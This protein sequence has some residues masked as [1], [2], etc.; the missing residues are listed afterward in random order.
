M[1][2]RRIAA[3]EFQALDAVDLALPGDGFDPGGLLLVHRDDQLADLSVRHAVAGEEIVQQAASAHAVLR[4][5][6]PV[7]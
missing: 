1:R 6:E 4:A 2:A 3:K 7:G 5:H